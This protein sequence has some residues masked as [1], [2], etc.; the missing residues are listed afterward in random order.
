MWYE[1]V[2]VIANGPRNQNGVVEVDGQLLDFVTGGNKRDY[3]K[4]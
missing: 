3:F 1:I 2:F 4:V